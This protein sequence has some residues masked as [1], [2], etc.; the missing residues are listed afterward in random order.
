M[1][2]R[3]K[4]QSCRLKRCR[5]V[6]MKEECLLSE[7]QCKARDAR[8]K[9]KQRYTTPKTD[10]KD[11]GSPG[12]NTIHES[13]SQS[14]LSES[15][16]SKPFSPD[17]KFASNMSP[18]SIVNP[19]PIHSVSLDSRKLIEK[20]VK[21]Q[22]K[23]EFPDEEK[24]ES[25]I[26]IDPSKEES[27]E[28]VLGSLARMTVIITHLIVEFAKN[29]PGFSR[30]SKEDQIVLLKSAS[31]EVMAIRASR[32]Y[33]PKTK[34]IVLANGMPLTMENMIQTRQ[35]PEYTELVFKLCHDMAEM[36]SD[37]A[38]YALFTSICIFSADR[39]GLSNRDLVEQI[40]RV[41]VDALDEYEKNKRL[42]GGCALAKYLLRLMDLR[43]ISE[44][45]SKMLKDLPIHEQDMPAVVKDIYI[46]DDR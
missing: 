5:E 34:S 33:D 32:C 12:K 36:N 3:R 17:V 40:Q 1:W 15:S 43:N 44:E 19:E 27:G 38:E 9:A 7:E 24:T 46:Q 42:K 37:N 10:E 14:R 23:Y 8:R 20:V 6:G 22:D 16:D 11:T 2:M 35:P 31:S 45:H 13:N 26:D 30:L 29:L 18:Y 28:R 4:C 25:A 41:Y 21:L 39:N